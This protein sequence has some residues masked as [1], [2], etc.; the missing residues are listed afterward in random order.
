MAFGDW[1]FYLIG[2]NTASLEVTNPIVGSGSLATGKPSAD[3]TLGAVNCHLDSGFTVGL[4][5]GRIRT[6]FQPA[7]DT[8]LTSVYNSYI[9]GMYFMSDADDL[10]TGT[11]DFYVA[12]LTKAYNTAD[13]WRPIIGKRTGGTLQGAGFGYNGGS[14]GDVFVDTA[15]TITLVEDNTI[16]LQI[17]WN[18]DI[19][20]LGGLRITM[21]VGN[22]GDTDFGNLAVVYDFVDATP[23][24][25]ATSEGLATQSRTSSPGFY[26]EMDEYMA[27]DQTGVFQLV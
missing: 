20:A 25:V 10:T 24:T 2:N 26:W 6:I 1:D 5:K 19:A 22:P 7:F 23:F 8:T 11:P 3:A 13:E 16:S 17:E 15:S 4:E 12:C 18:L 14:T 27:Y 9:G 21:S